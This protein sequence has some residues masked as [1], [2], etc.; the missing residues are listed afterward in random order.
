MIALDLIKPNKLN[1]IKL[2]QKTSKTPQTKAGWLFNIKAVDWKL[3]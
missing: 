2:H 1:C 3:L